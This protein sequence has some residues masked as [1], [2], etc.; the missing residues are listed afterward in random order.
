MKRSAAVF[1]ASEINRSTP[2]TKDR[3]KPSSTHKPSSLL[4]L[5]F[6]TAALQSNCMKTIPS[7]LTL[8]IIALAL[9]GSTMA[10]E[11]TNAPVSKPTV[12]YVTDFELHAAD[13][14]SDQGLLPPPPKLPGPLGEALPRPPG[15]PKDPKKLARELVDD[16][17]EA[18]VKR[19]TRAGF[20]ACRLTRTNDLPTDG[21]LVR[22]LF[23]EVNQGNQMQRS[24]IGFGLGKTDLQVVV[25]IA[26]LA[27]GAPTPF[28][29]VKTAANSGKLP[30]AAPVAALNP[31]AGA[32]R[33]VLAGGDLNRN[34]KQTAAQ[35]VEEVGKRAGTEP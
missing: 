31:A 13:I 21:W 7:K 28:Y 1:S 19:L 9:A 2:Q 18:L 30:G 32:A 4:R 34:V 20:T 8:A 24:M 5:V 26:D 33:F 12:I 22:G 35:I 17:S 6:G 25:D 14:K 27:Q 16:M 29:E 3:M 11:I 10:N 15:T 23:T